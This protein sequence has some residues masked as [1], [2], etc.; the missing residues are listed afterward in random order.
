MPGRPKVLPAAAIFLLGLAANARA[1][2]RAAGILDAYEKALGPAASIRTLSSKSTLFSGRERMSGVRTYWGG[3]GSW[4]RVYRRGRGGRRTD[5]FHDGRAY[6]YAGRARARYHPGERTTRAFHYA[7][8]ALARPF[9]LLAYAGNQ[10][11]QAGLEVG[12]AP[13]YDVL[14]TRPDAHGVR[15]L[16]AVDRKTGRLAQV[17]FEEEPNR[18][19]ATLQFS[20]YGPVEG[21]MLPRLVE[22]DLVIEREDA[23]KRAFVP[24]RV[25]W[26]ERVAEWTVNEGRFFDMAPPAPPEDLPEGFRRTVHE[27]L[28]DPHDLAI[29]DLDRD[30]KPDVAVC[31]FGGLAV[32]GGGALDE[33]L[34]VPLGEGTHRGCRIADLD[35]DGA[36]EVVVMS[37][38]NP[39]ATFFLVGFDGERKPRVRRIFGAPHHGYA[40]VLDDFDKDGLPDIAATGLASRNVSWHFGNGLG[41]VRSAGTGWTLLQEGKRPLPAHGLAAGDLNGDGLRDVAVAEPDRPRIVLF[42]GESN[43]SF[44]PRMALDAKNAGLARPVDVAFADLDG[45]G[46]EDLLFAQDHPLEE[47]GGDLGVVLNADGGL[48]VVGHFPAG[49]RFMAVRAA[50]LDGDGKPD[51]FGPSFLGD[52]LLWLEG[53]GDGTFE[54]FVSIGVARGPV[55]AEAGDVDGDGRPDVVVASTVDAAITVL[56]NA[57]GKAR[58][59]APP[60]KTEVIEAFREGEATLEGLSETYE[61]AGEWRLPRSIRDPSGLAF[62]HGDGHVDGLVL[63]S[64][65]EN[66]LFRATVDL[67]RHRLLVAPPIPLK[68]APEERLDLEG[69]AFDRES[70]TLFLACERDSSIWRTTLFGEFLGRAPTGIPPGDNSGIEA[71]ALRRKR[72]GTLLLYVFKERL[73]TTGVQPPVY[74]FEPGEQPFSLAPRG[75]P[76]RVP[77]PLVDQTGAVADGERLFLVSRFTRAVAEIPFEGDGFG[78]EFLAMG[79][80]AVTEKL[81]GYPGLP[82]FGMVEAIARAEGSGDLYLL[83]DTNGK[84]VGRNAGPEGRLI[85]LRC[86]NPPA[87]R[88]GPDRVEARVLFIPFAGA[89]G[90]PE[91]VG[92]TREEARA[93]A[94]R[95][96][97]RAAAGADWDE[98]RAEC[99]DERGKIPEAFTAVRAPAQKKAGELDERGLPPALHRL[100]FALDAGETEVCEHHPRL[101]PPGYYV[102]RRV[103]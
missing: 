52:R 29:A 21:V 39:S 23:E 2:D 70:G 26:R 7:A 37:W 13:G 3:D 14:A 43:L 72:D 15:T 80:R 57:N 61:F 17:R 35:L 31:G 54:E 32:H 88:P 41:G 6:L 85:R 79:Y 99:H 45:D 65:K 94:E 1:E 75:E 8:K 89:K 76:L 22:V 83:V 90:A 63:L 19:F 86:T 46:D 69:A 87:A 49:D 56:W 50:D 20:Q 55:R 100:L 48:R 59:P 16:F 81:L 96:R 9:A 44:H 36:P 64:D 18:P 74:V 38:T 66:A 12:E 60:A 82:A 53:K 51:A 42:R 47:I 71:I 73:G 77:A 84:S 91:G 102:V 11:A 93:L 5:R 101:C 78:K 24:G 25:A 58:P 30:G 4:K 10:K 67:R 97:K 33:P 92:R 62:L 27:T 95:C 68:N 98:L 28:P 34:V 103:E 40:L